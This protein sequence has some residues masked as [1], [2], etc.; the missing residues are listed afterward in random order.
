MDYH[1][2]SDEAIEKELFEQKRDVINMTISTRTLSDPEQLKRLNDVIK[3][4]CDQ[5]GYIE[6]SAND[7]LKYVSSIMS[8]EK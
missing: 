8:R 2:M 4:L 1:Y 7:L 3:T 6:E 5:Y